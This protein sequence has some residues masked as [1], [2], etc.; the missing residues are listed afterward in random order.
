MHGSKISTPIPVRLPNE[1]LVALDKMVEVGG[2]GNRS[3]CIRAFI[4]PNFVMAKTAMETKSLA[5]CVQAR[6]VAEHALMTHINQMI[7][8]SAIQTD[9]DGDLAPA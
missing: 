9:F 8:E 7:K 1:D 3:E 4:Q 6:L 2:F 5:K